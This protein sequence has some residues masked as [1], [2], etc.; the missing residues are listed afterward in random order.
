MPAEPTR[1]Q[2]SSRLAYSQG[3]PSFLQKL[4]NQVAGVANE[5][6]DAAYD[7]FDEWQA[8][9][10]RPPIPQRPAIPERPEGDAGSADEDDGDEKPQVVVLKEGKHLTELEVA[11]EKRRGWVVAS[12]VFIYSMVHRSIA[13][14]LPPLPSTSGVIDESGTSQEDDKRKSEPKSPSAPALSFSSTTASKPPTKKR[15][16]LGDAKAPDAS[17]DKSDKKDKKKAKKAKSG[18]LLSF[19]DGND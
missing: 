14:G 16:L 5:D 11:N 17:S 12:F 3:T 1:Q 9:S 4:K 6:D 10:G 18:A 13:K 7:D 19:G 8:S 2:L 15:K